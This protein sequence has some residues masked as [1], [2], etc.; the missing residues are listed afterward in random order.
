MILEDCEFFLSSRGHTHTSLFGSPCA[1]GQVFLLSALLMAQPTI[2]GFTLKCSALGTRLCMAFSPDLWSVN[3][4]ISWFPRAHLT[5]LACRAAGSALAGS[6]P[7]LC[8]SLFLT[9]CRLPFPDFFFFFFSLRKISPKLTSVP[10]FL[11]FI[12]GSPATAWL[13]TWC[14]GLHPGPKLANLGPPKKNLGA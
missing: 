10:I 1:H 3:I 8:P 11:Y 5:H 13:D 12:C 9:P 7:G 2:Q 14:V 6:M 4:H